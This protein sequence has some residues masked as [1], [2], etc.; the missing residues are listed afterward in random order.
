MLEITNQQHYERVRAFAE[1]KGLL[2]QFEEQVAYLRKYAD[3]EEK[4]LMKVLLGYD[5]APASFSLVWQR[6]TEKGE[7]EFFMNGA[8]IY[9]ADQQGWHQEEG[10]HVD[11]LAIVVGEEKPWM[12][13]T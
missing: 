5:F 3:P 4:G 7:Y 10:K 6:R 1:K 9:H 8:L 2:E 13:H 11:P 12:I